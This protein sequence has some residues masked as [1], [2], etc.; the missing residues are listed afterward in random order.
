MMRANMMNEQKPLL[1]LKDISIRFGFVEALKNINLGIYPH[2]I[3]AIVGDNGAGKSTLVKVLGGLYQPSSGS[4]VWK[5]KPTSIP[6]VHAANALGIASVFQAQE[7]C[8]NLDVTSNLFLGREMRTQ[9]VFRDDSA[10]FERAREV[11]N[12]LS[13]PIRISQ[14]V[15]S[16]SIGQRQTVAIARTLLNDPDLVL[17]D[18]PTDSLSV[19]Q[20][21]EVLS[22]IKRIRMQG[23]AIVFV[24]HDLPDIFAIADRIVVLRQGRVNGVH[25]IRD[26]SYEEIIAEI[27]GVSEIEDEFAM[28]NTAQVVKKMKIQ[29]QLID[30]SMGSEPVD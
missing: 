17:L 3:L 24:S 30:R 18:E 7:F 28:M 1:E 11:L 2:E 6:S 22:Y 4:L 10:M 12:E 15:S 26:T 20:V 14:P 9:R 19:V 5:S 16:L 27:S 23:R 29:R 13:S 25:S 8:D 21:G